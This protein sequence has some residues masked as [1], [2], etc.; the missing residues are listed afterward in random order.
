MARKGQKNLREKLGEEAYLSR[1]AEIAKKGHQTQINNV[2]VELVRT[3]GRPVTDEEV[4]EAYKLEVKNR[5]KG[6]D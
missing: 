4:L 5:L 3:L 1:L 2:R 6:K